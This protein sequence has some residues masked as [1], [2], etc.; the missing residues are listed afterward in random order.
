M[1]TNNERRMISD[2][3]GKSARAIVR[4]LSTTQIQTVTNQFVAGNYL[5][6]LIYQNILSLW[7]PPKT[8]QR[9][10]VLDFLFSCHGTAAIL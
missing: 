5:S 6:N 1:K 9:Q 8:L 10:I 4:T 2:S 3:F 7:T